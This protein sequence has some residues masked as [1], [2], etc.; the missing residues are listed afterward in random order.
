MVDKVPESCKWYQTWPVVETYKDNLQ[1]TYRYFTNNMTNEL[2]EKVYKMYNKYK[3]AE[4]GR[5]LF[6]I[7]MINKLLSNTTKVVNTLAMR[8]KGFNL[9][10]LPG[11]NIDNAVSLLQGAITCLSQIKK[12]KVGDEN[13]QEFFDMLT[14]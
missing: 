8:I 1:Y 13:S 3:P 6:F 9:Q 5:P 7:I 10:T 12:K 4:K 11:K 14:E 2:W